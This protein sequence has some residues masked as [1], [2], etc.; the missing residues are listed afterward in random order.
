MNRARSASIGAGVV[1]QLYQEGV[2][3][4]SQPPVSELH[5]QM[6]AEG[7]DNEIAFLTG[8]CKGVENKAKFLNSVAEGDEQLDMFRV[9]SGSLSGFSGTDDNVLKRRYHSVENGE[10]NK[11][12][13][14]TKSQRNYDF[15]T[16]LL[17]LSKKQFCVVVLLLL[18]I[19]LMLI[20]A[21]DLHNVSVFGQNSVLEQL[22]FG[23]RARNMS[24]DPRDGI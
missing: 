4:Y 6:I 11:I 14:V 16:P 24:D 9:T 20:M 21:Y 15:R 12:R 13:Y 23:D 22:V 18:I 10:N 5:G 2:D 17:D 19:A 7:R 3:P 1:P 8:F